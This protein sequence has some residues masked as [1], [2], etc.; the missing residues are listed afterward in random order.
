MENFYEITTVVLGVYIVILH[1]AKKKA[2]RMANRMTYTVDKISQGEWRAVPT[3]SGFEV[4]DAKGEMVIS[5]RDADR[6][7]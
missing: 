6:A 4:L 3:K 2:T 5:V 1:M 7:K